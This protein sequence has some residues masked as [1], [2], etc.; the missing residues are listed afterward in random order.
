MVPT[1][2][3]AL[4]VLESKDNR[5]LAAGLR[6]APL[7]TQAAA[8]RGVAGHA[9]RLARAAD[10]AGREAQLVEEMARLGSLL[11]EA[12]VA[13]T[14]LPGPTDG[15]LLARCAALPARPPA[16]ASASARP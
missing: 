1:N 14:K 7:R 8:I 13:L 15:A 2:S 12:A 6:R 5:R 16:I 10:V 9:E 4:A 11:L 3:P